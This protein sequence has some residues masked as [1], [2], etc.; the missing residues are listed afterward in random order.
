[1]K[2]F[3]GILLLSIGLISCGGTKENTTTTQ[4]PS[5]VMG[6][7]FAVVELFTSEGCS[8]C[9]L[10]EALMPKIKNE[11]KNNVYILEFHVDYWDHNGWKDPYSDKA[12]STRQQNYADHFNKNNPTV[13]TPQAIVNGKNGIN[14]SVEASLKSLINT[15][16]QQN[17]SKDIELNISSAKDQITVS[18]NTALN[19]NEVIN[20]ALVQLK[21]ASN[22]KGGE[23][24]GK[25]LEHMNVVRAFVSQ[26]KDNGVVNITMPN[27]L[28]PRDL[29]IIAYTQNTASRYITGAKEAG[30]Q[31]E[32]LVQRL[33]K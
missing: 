30:I 33:V 27:D 24:T 14:G 17:R 2:R 1:M 29:H 10:A 12:Y 18:Y 26:N 31:K 3:T 21:P 5:A 20:I 25:A 23:N 6:N 9:P 11:Y 13:Y 32:G 28:S 16:L 15:E 8:S 4:A 19:N 22:I 7:G